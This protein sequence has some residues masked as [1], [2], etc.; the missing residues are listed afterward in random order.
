[1]RPDSRHA[2]QAQHSLTHQ[3][4]RELARGDAG[5]ATLAA[6]ARA[7]FSHRLLLFDLL[8]DAV[9]PFAGL[10]SPLPA[11]ERAWD[12]LA[13]AQRQS[14]EVVEE[15][16]LLPETGLWLTRLLTRLR[17]P[18]GESTPLWAEIGHLHTLAAVAAARAGLTFAFPVPAHGGRVWLP[19][20]GTACLPSAHRHR[21]AWTAVES[22]AIHGRLH[23]TGGYGHLRL[24][25]LP[26]HPAS[27]WTPQRR[28]ALTVGGTA[29]IVLD[30]LGRHRIAP[31]PDGAPERLTHSAYTAWSGLLQAAYALVSAADPPTAAAADVLLRSVQPMPAHE[32]FRVRSVSSGHGV[33]G[34]AS[35][36][37]DSVT[38]WA[39]TL[40]HELQHSKLSALM[41]LYPLHEEPQAPEDGGPPRAEQPVRLYY[42]PWRDDPRPL[43]G[44][45]QG[46]YAFAA[47]ARFWR[48]RARCPGEPDI[49]LAR[50]ETA[51]WQSQL[52]RVLPELAA[53]PAVTELGREALHDLLDAVSRR[54]DR[55]GEGPEEA[56]AHRMAAD[57]RAAWRLAHV[58]PPPDAVARL[59]AA[60]CAAR[61]RPPALISR[62]RPPTRSSTAR[63]LD[64]RA[65]LV[66]IGL[67]DPAALDK[68]GDS[69]GDTVAGVAGA[70]PADLLWACG[71]FAAALPCYVRDISGDPASPGAWSGLRLVLADAGRAPEA[72]RALTA[73]P[74]LVAAVH[75][76]VRR[77]VGRPPDPVDL[78]RWLGRA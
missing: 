41:H 29:R 24:P 16:V 7:E 1:M 74:E 73:A 8:M 11:P 18:G 31:L 71:D 37:S 5:R 9:S 30:D 66:R 75:R 69:P 43:G 34:F 6:L 42:A 67:T 53:D 20:L 72:V 77:T 4:F 78:A 10:S 40:V 63:H 15:L 23:L 3:Q 48:A 12:L 55:S 33:G 35:S 70:T 27:G 26:E 22:R 60:W 64:A 14:P 32:R 19:T 2:A 57:H 52:A 25:T 65:M 59:S 68:M 76:T 51:L 21:T 44:M 13:A 47:V 38:V 62:P 54:R 61:E 49:A 28:L 45:L 56:M 36:M 17:A 50:F 58:P 46:A 39:A